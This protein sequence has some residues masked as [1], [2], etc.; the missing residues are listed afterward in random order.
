M[1]WIFPDTTR[2]A[3]RHLRR[4]D[5]VH[6]SNKTPKSISALS[7]LV[8]SDVSSG[9]FAATENNGLQDLANGKNLEKHP[10]LKIGANLSTKYKAN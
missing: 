1:F 8:L 10:L 7:F 3:C 2:N 6:D 9:E 4:C 5:L